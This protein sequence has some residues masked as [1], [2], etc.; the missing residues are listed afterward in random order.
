MKDLSLSAL[1]REL[2]ISHAFLHDII[3]NRRSADDYAERMA[4]ILGVPLEQLCLKAD[5]EANS[6]A[7]SGKAA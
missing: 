2:G 6:E 1:A 3:R 4:Q 5:S 7:D